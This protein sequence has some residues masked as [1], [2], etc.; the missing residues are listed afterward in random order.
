MLGGRESVSIVF[1]DAVLLDETSPQCF[2]KLGEFLVD[3]GLPLGVD[4]QRAPIG[5][6]DI[7][8]VVGALLGAQ[9]VST[10][11]GGIVETRFLHDLPAGLDELFLAL[12]LVLERVLD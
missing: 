8:I 10:T 3:L 5:L 7:A 9:R 12:N 11:L 4:Y 2:G 1:G 6:R